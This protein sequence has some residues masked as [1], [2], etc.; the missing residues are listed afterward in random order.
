[1][2]TE[3]L[4]IGT[5]VRCTMLLPGGPRTVPG[6]VVRVTALPR[7]LGIA[8]AF[9]AL[10]PGAT[11]AIAQLVEARSRDV[12]PARLRV[13]GMEQTL[14]CE[15]RIDEGTVR[16]TAALPFLRLDGGVDVVLGDDGQI[17]AG[18]ISRI[19]LDPATPD[20]VPR[21]ALEVSLAGT[22]GPASGSGVPIQLSDG[23]TPPPTRLPPA[24]G[25]PMPSVVVSKT[26]ERDLRRAEERPPRRK[27]HSTAEIARRPFLSE[28]S[29]SAPPPIVA[30][31]APVRDTAR[32]E[33][34][35][36]GPRSW[37]RRSSY[38]LMIVPV[39][40]AVA[41]LLSRI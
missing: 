8:V 27:V 28:L 24:F 11:A 30:T 23:L 7:G 12:R 38:L 35:P 13:D 37:V 21:L 36:R 25:H 2:C 20:G 5:E 22:T 17:A 14:R 32:V 19:A 3:S 29:W 6:R 31:V 4:P 41:A 10:S 18:T 26:L 1:M 39:V 33:L 15:G 40:L 9:E 34:L 16:L